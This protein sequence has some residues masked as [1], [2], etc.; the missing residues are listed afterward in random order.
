M[1]TFLIG[2]HVTAADLIVL[3][4]ALQ[5]LS[6]LSDYDK[7]QHPHVFRWANH[8]QHLPGILE[9]VQKAELFVSFPDLNSK[10]P[11]KSELKKLAKLKAAQEKKAGKKAEQSTKPEEEE[12]KAEEKKSE[13]K[14]V[15]KK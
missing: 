15:E 6:V 2:H 8:I 9:E 5:G 10:K 13:D 7:L 3:M 12:K 4:P 11:S 1:R 14:K